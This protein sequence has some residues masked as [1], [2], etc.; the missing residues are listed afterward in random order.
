MARNMKKAN[1]IVF[2]R[3]AELADSDIVRLSESTKYIKTTVDEK[4]WLKA[5]KFFRN[6]DLFIDRHRFFALAEF[7]SQ[8]YVLQIGCG[9]VGHIDE[10]LLLQQ[11]NAGLFTALVADLGLPLLDGMNLKLEICDQVFL[12]SK[13][14]EVIGFECADI[15]KYFVSYFCYMVIPDSTLWDQDNEM[16]LQKTALYLL[17]HSPEVIYLNASLEAMESLKTLARLDIKIVPFDRI[18]R[19]FIERRYEHAFLD[20]YRCLE[21]LFSLKKIDVLRSRLNLNTAHLEISADI[22]DALGWRPVE[23]NALAEI[24]NCFPDDVIDPLK[25]C[26]NN[27]ADVSANVYNLRNECVHFRPLQKKSILAKQVDW[28]FLLESMASVIYYAYHVSYRK[29]F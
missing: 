23:K 17:G 14:S 15:E 3:L 16:T 4:N 18:F 2:D 19:A 22:E 8:K 21:M 13:N 10:D 29:M 28:A 25:S 7:Q 24:F 26:F 5:V 9:P 11:S 12:P 27:T 1:Q 20:L 6:E